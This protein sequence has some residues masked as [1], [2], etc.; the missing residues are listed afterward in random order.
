MLYVAFLVGIGYTA[1]LAVLLGIL[2]AVFG[3]IAFQIAGAAGLAAI[4]GGATVLYQALTR[5]LTRM[6]QR[7]DHLERALDQIQKHENE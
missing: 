4:V 7:L 5:R 6:E 3:D 2:R 1:A